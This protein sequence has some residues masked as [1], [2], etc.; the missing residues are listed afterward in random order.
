MQNS[1]DDE[2]RITLRR[3]LWVKVTAT[4]AICLLGIFVAFGVLE[5]RSN[6]QKLDQDMMRRADEVTQLL[7][8]QAG[9]AIQTGDATA[10]D[11]VLGQAMAQVGRDA[12]A[13]ITIDRAGKTLATTDMAGNG[14]LMAAACACLRFADIDRRHPGFFRCRTNLDRGGGNTVDEQICTRGAC[15]SVLDKGYD[16]LC[17]LGRRTWRAGSRGASI[18]IYAVVGFGAGDGADYSGR[19]CGCRAACGPT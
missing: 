11:T 12:V 18:G 17:C 13:A 8:L 3:S 2:S 1:A 19:R 9:A 5:H 15:R 10:A 4:L 16:R 14:T 7:A 6:L